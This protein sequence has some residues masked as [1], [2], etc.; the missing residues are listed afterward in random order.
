MKPRM[1][2]ALGGLAITLLAVAI[3]GCASAPT[4]APVQLS[5]RSLAEAQRS[6]SAAVAGAR[7]P[8]VGLALGGGGLRGFA[9]LGVLRALDEACIRPDIVVGTSAG[10]IIGAAYASGTAPEE[11]AATARRL[12]LS[13]LIGR[14]V[15]KS[16]RM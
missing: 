13:S 12:K 7:R 8:T 6:P 15:A 10:A 11:L 2:Q 3:V 14:D 5:P 4:S 16:I 9:H 1:T